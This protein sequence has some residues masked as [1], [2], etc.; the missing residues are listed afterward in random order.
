MLNDIYKVK[1]HSDILYGA[2][3][4][5]T[6]YDRLADEISAD[7]ST[8][9]PILLCVMN[10]GLVLTAELLKRLTFPLLL[11][12]VHATRYHDSTE[13]GTIQWLRQPTASITGKDVLIIDDILDEG[14]TMQQI[15][16]ACH[17]TG[18]RSVKSAVLAIK[19]HDRRVDGVCVDYSGVTVEDRYVYG[20]GMDYR[21]Y[22]RNETSIYA[23]RETKGEVI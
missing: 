18:A 7:L 23:L 20:C 2:A 12:Y 15:Q 8:S 16:Q 22:F 5:S 21:G 19:Q 14:I 6:V 11:D 3:Q 17:E 1:S 9:M 4:L 10:G 13:A